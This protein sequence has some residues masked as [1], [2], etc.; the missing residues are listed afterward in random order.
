MTWHPLTQVN[1]DFFRTAP[2]SFT[3]TSDFPVPVEQLWAALTADDAVVSWSPAVTGT[4]WEGEPR[5]IGTLREVTVLGRLGLRDRYYRWDENFR[6]TF[7][8]Q[9]TTL[10]GLRSFAED[11]V[12]IATTAGSRLYWTVALEFSRH[13]RLIVP[14]IR[15]VLRMV[16]GQLARGVHR[17]L[18]RPAGQQ[19]PA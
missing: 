6:M 8:A 3:I 13:N 17:T 19:I 14:V 5:G 11:Y 12:I 10:P 4:R 1:D 16:F 15:P 7:S 18:L 9:E 2:L